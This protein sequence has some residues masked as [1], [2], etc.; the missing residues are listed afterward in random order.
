M[1]YHTASLPES[2]R[3][4]VEEYIEF[5]L[6]KEEKRI[7]PSTQKPDPQSFL[8]EWTG[9]FAGVDAAQAKEDYLSEKYQ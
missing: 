1:A 4:Q 9:Y 8:R 2:I 3:Q 7:L 6:W 5:L